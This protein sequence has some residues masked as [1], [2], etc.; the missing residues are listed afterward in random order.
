MQAPATLNLVCYQGATFDYLLTW[1]TNGT[2]VD[3]TNY[4]ARMQVR[5]TYNGHTAIFSLVS[6]TGITLGGTAGTIL[7]EL[8]ATAT[9]GAAEGQ[10]AYDLELIYDQNVTR[11]VEGT[12]VID[13]EVTQ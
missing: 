11:L 1:K 9:A 13:P 5:D 12:F 7:L 6:G 4:S 2:A 3:L 10:Y 8:D